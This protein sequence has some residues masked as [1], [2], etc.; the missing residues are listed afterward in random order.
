[1]GNLRFK[2]GKSRQGELKRLAR[3]T[4]QESAGEAGRSHVS[5]GDGEQYRHLEDRMTVS[6]EVKHR[7]AV[8][9]SHSTARYISKNGK[10][11]ST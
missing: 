6:Q 7:T 8:S 5:G 9:P 4:R 2:C 1:M 10:H 11:M 3:V